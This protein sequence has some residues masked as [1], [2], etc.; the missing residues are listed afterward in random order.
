MGGRAEG[1]EKLASI[2]SGSGIGHGKNSFAGMSQG[3]IKLIV[4]PVSRAAGTGSRRTPALYHKAF[5]DPVKDEAVVKI[6][7]PVRLLAAFGQIDKIPYG[8]GALFGV[9]FSLKSTLIGFKNRSCP[10]NVLFVVAFCC[11]SRLLF[12]NFYDFILL[13]WDTDEHG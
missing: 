6:S 13:F 12:C 4:E 9:K 5:D 11:H 3:R 8:F 7:I 2:G 1:D 10:F